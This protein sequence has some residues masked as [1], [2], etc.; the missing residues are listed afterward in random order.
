MNLFRT[1]KLERQNN[2]GHAVT[3]HVYIQFECII[4][5][6][7]K[8]LDVYFKLSEFHIVL[9]FVNHLYL[10]GMIYVLNYDIFNARPALKE[11][12]DINNLYYLF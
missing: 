9:N 12:I 10:T 1:S 7:E 4:S 2:E 3:K 11:S 6:T 5:M 8:S